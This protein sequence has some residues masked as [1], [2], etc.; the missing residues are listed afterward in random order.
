MVG[1]HHPAC[2]VGSYSS[3]P[4]ADGTPQ[5]QVNPTKVL[6]QQSH[7]VD[8]HAHRRKLPVPGRPILCTLRL[9]ILYP[10]DVLPYRM[11]WVVI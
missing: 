4:P 5:I 9:T 6:D 11:Y 10:L 3:G 2:S 7:P 8:T 1:F